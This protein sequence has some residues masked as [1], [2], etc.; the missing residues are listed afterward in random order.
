VRRLVT[1]RSRGQALIETAF[2]LPIFLIVLFGLLWAMQSGVLG[3][4]AQVVARYGGLVSSQSNAFDQFSFYAAYA[5][6]A[7]TPVAL[8]CPTPPPPLVQDAGPVAA[9]A[10]PSAPF[11]QPTAIATSAT[12][13]H[14]LV[15]GGTLSG[16]KVLHLARFTVQT[17]NAVPSI[18][19]NAL[20]T[21]TTRGAD[22]RAFA[23]PDMG[24]LIG[25]YPELQAA[26]AA[27]VAPTQPPAANPPSPPALTYDT[28]PLA[29]SAS[30]S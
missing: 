2:A 23:S 7:G 30:C 17:Q 20:G 1:L 12:C 16:T 11:W 25:C 18:L 28:S 4:R 22:L 24:A 10:Q 14:A 5:A 8:P 15:A 19:T 9:P 6:A 26:F 29:I 27:S 3:E 13:G 21:T